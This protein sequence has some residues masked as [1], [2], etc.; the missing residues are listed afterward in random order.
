[1]TSTLR[2]GDL[3]RNVRLSRQ[4]TLGGVADQYNLLLA[5]VQAIMHSGL[6]TAELVHQRSSQL[7]GN[8]AR[9]ADMAGMQSDATVSTSAAVEEVTVSVGEVAENVKVAF[10]N[11]EITQSDSE[12]GE[13]SVSAAATAINTLLQTTSDAVE[14]MEELDAS[15]GKISHI[16][17]VI[18]DIAGQTNLLA[19]N[20]AIEAARA[21][22]QGRGFAVVADEVRKLAER[23]TQATAEI[24]LTLAELSK[25]TK[26]AT[27]SI[28]MSHQQV[29]QI[30][31]LAKSAREVLLNIGHSAEQTRNMLS[32]ISLASQE[33]AAAA[34]E[35][36]INVERISQGAEQVKIIV[37]EVAQ[38]A[39]LLEQ[40][41][42]GMKKELSRV[43]F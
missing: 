15:S 18:R 22:E 6:T 26:T 37:D 5:N 36:A 11:A 39:I 30:T 10:H 28:A 13:K 20:A 3:R 33:E 21:G 23:T 31:A 12:D 41:A 29:Q 25:E 8:T 27:H 24:D 1:M 43:Q 4:D 19:L 14:V 42:T 2:D 38:V 16:A 34:T 9:A 32:E 7:T 40:M 17:G 35:I